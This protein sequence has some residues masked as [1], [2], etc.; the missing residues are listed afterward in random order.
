MTTDKITSVKQQL[1]N[2]GS[3]VYT[4]IKSSTRQSQSLVSTKKM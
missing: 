3:R 4:S 1:F 2:R